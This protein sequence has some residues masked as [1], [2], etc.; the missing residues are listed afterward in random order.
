L[1]EKERAMLRRTTN[2]YVVTFK[3]VG[4]LVMPIIVQVHYADNT[5][6]VLRIPVDIW[7]SNG[8]SVNKLIVTE[9][10]ITR[11]ELD[12]KSELADTEDAN[13]HWPPKITPSRFKLFKDETK[14]NPMQKLRDKDKPDEE[15]DQDDKED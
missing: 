3:N 11:M 10:E 2:F 5:S 4:G 8:N 7:R 9:K 15:E 12:P 1:D 13:N 14:K 6:E